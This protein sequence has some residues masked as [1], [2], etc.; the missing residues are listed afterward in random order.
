MDRRR[1]ARPRCD[2]LWS[3]LAERP[4]Q[5]LI[6]SG[7]SG[8]VH[9]YWQLDRAAARPPSRASGAVIEPIERAQPAGSSAR[10]ASTPT[11]GRD[12]ADPRCAERSRVMRLAGTI[13]HKSGAWARVLEADLALPAYPIE[14]LVG[15]LPDPPSAAS[16]AAVAAR[17]A[18]GEDPYK[19]IA[20]PEYFQRLAG[21]SVP[22]GGLVSC[23]VPRHRDRAPVLQRRHRARAGLVLPQRGCGARGAIYDL[24]SV[25]TAGRG[26][27]SCAATAFARARARVIEMFGERLTRGT[28]T[29]ARRRRARTS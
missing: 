27:G 7:G 5:L 1:P 22:R 15:D 10:S 14:D 24:A 20:P 19:R 25:L 4:C 21:I 28:A 16:R 9:A 29:H 23:P 13:N 17:D 8:G 3:L 26:A 6:A 11:G 2:A 18:A 12:V